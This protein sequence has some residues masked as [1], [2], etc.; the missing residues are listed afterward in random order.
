VKDGGEM[1]ILQEAS[2]RKSG[3]PRVHTRLWKTNPLA[4]RVQGNVRAGHR[5]KADDTG[6]TDIEKATELFIGLTPEDTIV[7]I[8]EH[9]IGNY[10]YYVFKC[11]YTS[12][13][14]GRH[15][16]ITAK[17]EQ[18]PEDVGSLLD[19]YVRQL[20]MTASEVAREFSR[21]YF[22]E[23]RAKQD[24]FI[25]NG[26]TRNSEGGDAFFVKDETASKDKLSFDEYS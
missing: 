24:A 5:T 19:F 8:E 14:S 6:L 26:Y 21:L 4:Q 7:T 11:M 12:K 23:R 9:S 22:L 18:L 1:H 3:G 17:G 15:I 16:F 2:R 25:N 13:S 20:T 10:T